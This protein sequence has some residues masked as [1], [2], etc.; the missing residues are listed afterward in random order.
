MKKDLTTLKL[1]ISAGTVIKIIV[2]LA[3]AVI[4]F[5]L[6]DLILLL[7]TAIVVASSVEPVT[8]WCI[9][10]RMPRLPAVILIY[11][12]LAVILAGLF[13]FLFLPFLGESSKFVSDLPEYID[14]S[15]AALDKNSFIQS[16]PILKNIFNSTSISDFVSEANAFL[17]RF[18]GGFWN[19]VSS[20]FGSFVSLIIVLVFSFYLAAQE[21]GV[22]KFLKIVT[23][24]KKEAYVIDLWKRVEIKIGLWMQGQLVLA[25]LVGLIVYGG[26]LLFGVPHALLLGV[27]AALCELIPLFGPIIAAIPAIMLAFVDGGITLALFTTGFYG[28][29]QQLEN[30]IIYP[31]IVKKVVGISPI[32][33]IIAIIAGAQLA[34]FLG[35]LLSVPIAAVL[36]EFISDL[37]LKRTTEE[38]ELAQANSLEN[39]IN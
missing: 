29:V 31:Q 20:I 3:A 13:Y 37:E 26:M 19:S 25:L 35:V 17:G 10:R 27:L 4:V 6:R 23:P 18:S 36:M 30:H 34:G 21:N 1:D 24:R 39:K 11:A 38:A 5:M 7:L 33:V 2:V 8:K 28:I 15:S 16:K 14:K 32:I 9:R 22:G 12:F